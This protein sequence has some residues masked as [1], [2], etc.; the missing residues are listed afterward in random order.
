MMNLRALSLP[1]LAIGLSSCGGELES[2]ETRMK[3]A[4][5]AGSV[6]IDP[7][8]GAP[9]DATM[10]AGETATATNLAEGPDV[11]FRAIAKHLGA[12]AKVSEIV[13]FFSPGSEIDGDATEPAG[14]MTVCKVEYQDP[15]DPRKLL[16]TQL[17]VKSGIFSEPS[18]V[19]I[20]VTGGGAATFKLEDYLIPLAKVD[21]AALKSV[22]D[23]QKAKLGGIYDRYAWSGV[24]LM[25]P[26]AFSDKHSLRL[27][28]TGRLA[29]NDVKQVGFASISIDGRTV[30]GN[31]LLP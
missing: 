3:Q 5:S 6:M 29:A 14:Q 4:E 27:D 24:R 11:C 23:G 9:D 30:T 12:N 17:D 19:E 26:G 21:A 2:S 31:R 22:M 15:N 10:G 18:P 16:S 1:L 20:T 25:A 8:E 28:L 7:G 13:S